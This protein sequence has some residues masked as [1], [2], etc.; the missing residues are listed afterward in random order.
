M[1]QMFI[2][3]KNTHNTE[4]EVVTQNN[5]H[6]WFEGSLSEDNVKRSMEGRKGDY[7]GTHNSHLV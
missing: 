6:C 1:R 5:C 4:Q 2:A 3:D 7:N